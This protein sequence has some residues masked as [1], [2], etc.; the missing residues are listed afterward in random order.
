MRLLVPSSHSGSGRL[1]SQPTKSYSETESSLFSISYLA[2]VLSPHT[3][4]KRNFVPR[5]R[6]AVHLK[7][8]CLL[9]PPLL[10]HILQAAQQAESSRMMFIQLELQN[11]P[12]KIVESVEWV[13]SSK[14]SCVCMYVTLPIFSHSYSYIADLSTTWWYWTV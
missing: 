3:Y 9:L 6:P 1:P 14:I 10:A 11:V 7:Q 5:P 13:L 2:S 4:R 8:R 12:C